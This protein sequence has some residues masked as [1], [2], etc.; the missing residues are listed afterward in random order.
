MAPK[1][2]LQ[3]VLDYRHNHVEVLE[4]ELGRLQQAQ[5]RGQTFLEALQDSQG[6]IYEQLGE[7]QQGDLDLFM[8]SRLRTSLRFVNERI[9]EQQQRL[10]EI[11]E[12]VDAKRNEVITARQDEQA[13]VTLKTKEIERFQFE[14]NQK[15]NR[16]QDDIYI[17]RAYHRST[18]MA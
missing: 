5:K 1:F 12:Q 4:V 8:L 3:P 13:L 15:D 11:T 17:S 18:S 16:L 10:L 9:V 6:R 2:S 14:Q 7:C